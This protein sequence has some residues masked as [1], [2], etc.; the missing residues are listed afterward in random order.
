MLSEQHIAEL[1][2]SG[3]MTPTLRQLTVNGRPVYVEGGN[4][5]TTDLLLR[6]ADDA[7]RYVAEVGRYKEMGLNLIR[8]WG[9]G[10]WERE[11]FFDACD[12]AG[13]LVLQEYWMTGDNNGRWAGNYEWPLDHAA[14]LTNA[15]DAFRAAASLDGSS[16]KA[17]HAWAL[18]NYRAVQRATR[19][20]TDAAALSRPEVRAQLV[21]AARGFVRALALGTRR[22]AAS[23][24]QDLLNL[25]NLEA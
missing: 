13:M 18:A 3:R 4:W 9:G 19:R 10:L 23:A 17:W 25:L 5:I 22:R 21:A 11:A 20:R 15:A 8:V 16:Y 1:E 6:Y 24:Q 2:A 7:S 14:Y 12:A